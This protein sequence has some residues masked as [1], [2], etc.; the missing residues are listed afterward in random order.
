MLDRQLKQQAEKMEIAIEL[1]SDRADISGEEAEYFMRERLQDLIPRIL[2]VDDEPEFRRFAKD[3][4]TSFSIVEATSGQQ[5]LEIVQEERL[6]LIIADIRM[7]EMD[8]CT[9]LT[10]LRT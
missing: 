3:A 1:L 10:N 6:D 7:P 8:G 9:L 2:I 5:A 4:L